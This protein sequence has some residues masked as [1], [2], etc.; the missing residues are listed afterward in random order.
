MLHRNHLKC[1]KEDSTRPWGGF[2]VLDEAETDKFIE[3]YFPTLKK[4]DF[5]TPAKLSPKLL[6]VAPGKKIDVGNTTID[7]LNVETNRRDS[8]HYYK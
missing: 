5:T 1:I 6:I 3:L 2:F 8:G 7:V 4:E